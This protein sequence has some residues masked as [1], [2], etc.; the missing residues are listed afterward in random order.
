MKTRKTL[1]NEIA[2]ERNERQVAWSKLQAA[3]E[4]QRKA[5]A[6]LSPLQEAVSML[7]REKNAMAEEMRKREA[8]VLGQTF[9][10]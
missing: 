6:A 4:A 8:Q 7:E 5:R 9:F 3:E 2:Q 10:A 1:E